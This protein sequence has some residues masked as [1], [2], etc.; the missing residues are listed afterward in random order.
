MSSYNSLILFQPVNSHRCCL[1][2]QDRLLYSC[3]QHGFRITAWT[4]RPCWQVSTLTLCALRQALSSL[5]LDPQ[6]H[7]HSAKWNLPSDDT[8]FSN[9]DDNSFCRLFGLLSL[10]GYQPIQSRCVGMNYIQNDAIFIFLQVPSHRRSWTSCSLLGGTDARLR[11]RVQAFMYQI[12]DL[13]PALSHWK[14]SARR[15]SSTNWKGKNI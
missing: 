5:Q 15:N 13:N 2:S 10:T 9:V 14:K 7:P 4:S 8:V 3:P 1:H 6:E 12:P 11:G